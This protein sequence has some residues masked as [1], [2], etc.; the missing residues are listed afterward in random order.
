[1]WSSWPTMALPLKES[2]GR[3]D[4]AFLL[5]YLWNFLL[6]MA[7]KWQTG[8]LCSC[9]SLAQ[10]KAKPQRFLL[11]CWAAASSL[12][13]FTSSNLWGRLIS[14][15]TCRIPLCP[16]CSFSH[17]WATPLSSHPILSSSGPSEPGQRQRQL[18][19][20]PGRGNVWSS[21]VRHVQTHGLSS[22]ST[23]LVKHSLGRGY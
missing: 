21:S 8:A 18:L 14:R 23:K 19:L 2:I 5:E 13:H 6:Q 20:H 4:D 16:C 17:S 15:G 22:G 12:L 7:V 1:M 3:K 11:C 9:L 10:L